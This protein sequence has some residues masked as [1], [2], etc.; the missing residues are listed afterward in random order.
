MPASARSAAGSGS[1]AGLGSGQPDWSSVP[2]TSAV[3]TPHPIARRIPRR[4]SRSRPVAQLSRCPRAT[5]APATGRT[6]NRPDQR[7]ARRRVPR[8]PG[9]SPPQTR[10]PS[11]AL[12]QAARGLARR[13]EGRRRQAGESLRGSPRS[14]AGGE[15]GGTRCR[16]IAPRTRVGPGGGSHHS[17]ARGAPAPPAAQPPA[18]F[19]GAGL[20]SLPP[21]SASPMSYAEPS[22][23][24]PLRKPSIATLPTLLRR[25][26][27]SGFPALR[28]AHQ[29]AHRC[30]QDG[31]RSAP[32][33]RPRRSRAAGPPPP[34]RG[35]WR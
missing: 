1:I 33:L 18:A 2:C 20:S 9:P 23:L 12:P 10:S 6:R 27:R 3:P 15:R 13:R 16:A 35:W 22:T 24:R 31:L 30:A 29:A 25:W 34:R 7:R 5:T 17:V 14:G 21:G 19:A 28:R 32:R 11:D 8:P 4:R 26:P